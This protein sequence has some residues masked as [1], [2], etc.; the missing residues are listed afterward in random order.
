MRSYKSA[1]TIGFGF[2][3]ICIGSLIL[4]DNLDI[5]Y[6]RTVW[7]YFW[8]LLLI[9]IGLVLVFRKKT[10]EEEPEEETVNESGMAAE[11]QAK[12][13]LHDSDDQDSFASSNEKNRATVVNDNQQSHYFGNI[14]YSNDDK[15]FE[16]MNI[17]NI[18]GDI[19]ID[20]SKVDFSA[21]EK[22]VNISG[23]FGSIKVILP[24]N[25]PAKFI[26]SAVV[27]SV[28]FLDKDKDGLLASLNSETLD[29][30]DASKKLLIRASIIFGDILAE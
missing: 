30:D 5:L 9:M 20:I 13:A 6:F 15:D 18:F 8:P 1:W 3:F 26:G 24:K 16:G 25:I 4:L 2:F 14:N 21:G 7:S 22:I 11:P 29:Y 28:K 23:I 27:G 19:F 10:E 17:S 12:G